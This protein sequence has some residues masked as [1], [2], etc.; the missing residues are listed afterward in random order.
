MKASAGALDEYTL[1]DGYSNKVTAHSRYRTDFSNL[2]TNTSGR[3]G[4]TRGDYDYF[5]PDEAI[6]KKVKH[7][8]YR[9]D[10]IY[11]RVGLVKNVVDLMGD[12]ATQGIRIV[13][14]NKRVERFYKRWFEKINGKDRSERFVNNLYK[15]GNVVI[16][17]QTGKLTTKAAEGMFKALET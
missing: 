1:I 11:Q 9:A 14:R 7:V 15:T 4:L 17:R 16:D 5:R 8:M 6:P 3:P 13:H 10:D 12:F 2:D